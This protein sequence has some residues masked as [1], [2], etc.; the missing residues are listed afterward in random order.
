MALNFICA[1]TPHRTVVVVNRGRFH[2]LMLGFDG[3]GRSRT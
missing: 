2:F 1:H 3:V